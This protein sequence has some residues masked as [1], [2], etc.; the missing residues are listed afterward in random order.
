MNYLR[1][2]GSNP[3]REQWE[4]TLRW[5]ARFAEPNAD[6]VDFGLVLLQNCFALRDWLI[7]SGRVPTN[8]VATLF[9]SPALQLCRDIA[10]GSKHL[11]LHSAGVDA[12]HFLA[13]EYVPGPV[14]GGEA[15]ARSVIVADWVVIDLRDLCARC[16]AEVR[17]FLEDRGLLAEPN[18][19]ARGP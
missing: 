4:R 10:N 17:A 7:A 11:E 14:G 13:R 1:N 6:E 18:Y 5:A 8:D 12:D 9:S 2:R 19:L 16:L 15:S 3:V